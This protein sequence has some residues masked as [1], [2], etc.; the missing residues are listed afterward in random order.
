MKLNLCTNGVAVKTFD[1]RQAITVELPRVVKIDAGWADVGRVLLG[2]G[3]ILAITVPKVAL[4]AAGDTFANLHVSIMN[5]FDSG[6]V[7]VIIFAGA[8]WALG[9]RTK[10]IE[11]LIGVCAGYL[12]ARH[13]IDIRDFLKGI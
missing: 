9:H 10:A 3:S 1:F 7:L 6:I 12:L 13:A 2:A 4:A 5:M 11:I 8:C